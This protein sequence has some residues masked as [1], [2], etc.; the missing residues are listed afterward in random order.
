MILMTE[1]GVSSS[2]EFVSLLPTTFRNLNVESFN[3]NQREPD[4]T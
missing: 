1:A 4:C 2:E 3:L